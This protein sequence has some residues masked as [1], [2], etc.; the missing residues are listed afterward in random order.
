MSNIF[1][2]LFSVQDCK[3]N[4]DSSLPALPSSVRCSIPDYCTGV[5]CCVAEN[6]V[7]RHHFTVGVQLDDCNHILTF[8]VEKLKIEIALN[9]YNF[10]KINFMKAKNESLKF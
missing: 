9:G 8:E 6:S 3:K 4:L 10:G 5:T 7:L 1:I 2:I